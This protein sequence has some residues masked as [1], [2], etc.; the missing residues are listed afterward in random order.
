MVAGGTPAAPSGTLV[1]T[2]TSGGGPHGG[3]NEHARIV[4]RT[5]QVTKRVAQSAA[6]GLVA[7]RNGDVRALL[8]VGAEDGW[9][10]VPGRA[11][12]YYGALRKI[13]HRG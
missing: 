6:F 5:G 10:D 1:A 8:E 3:A 4:R 2:S 11:R 9:P 12:K 13:E 7:D